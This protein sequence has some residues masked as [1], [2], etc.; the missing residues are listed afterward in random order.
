[1][2]RAGLT[3]LLLSC[4]LAAFAAPAWATPARPLSDAETAQIRAFMATP[5]FNEAIWGMLATDVE[6]GRELFSLNA[7]RLFHTASTTKNFTTAAALDVLGPGHRFHT[8][9]LRRGPD[10]ILRASGDLTM[11]GRALPNGQVAYT[12][13]DHMDANEV[14]GEATLTPQSPLAGLDALARQARRR[15]IRS[16]RNV[17]I[18]DR[19]WRA[20]RVGHEVVSPILINENAIDITMRPTRPDSSCAH[21]PV[22]PPPPTT[23][24][25]ASGRSPRVSRR[26]C[27]WARPRAAR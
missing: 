8:P 17:G 21:R 13:F 27:S 26:A 5:P 23:S 16:V 4:V 9:L 15:G 7:E 24:T 3:L 20:K 10:L 19:L 1:M 18:D 12:G 22:R 25:C 11:G 14:P 2:T 6:T